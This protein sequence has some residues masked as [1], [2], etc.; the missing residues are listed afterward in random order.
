M[1]DYYLNR[2]T[3]TTTWRESEIDANKRGMSNKSSQMDC[4]QHTQE[5]GEEGMVSRMSFAK[6]QAVEEKSEAR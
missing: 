1:E 6:V 4:K 5:P 2:R 3:S